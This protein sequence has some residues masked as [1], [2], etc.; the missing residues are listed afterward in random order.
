MAQKSSTEPSAESTSDPSATPGDAAD[1]HPG[2]SVVRAVFGSRV[3]RAIMQV[4]RECMDPI[5]SIV[6]RY[7]E[8]IDEFTAIRVIPYES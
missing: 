2:N 4:E 3:G 8:I 6:A 1:Q 5:S 7:N